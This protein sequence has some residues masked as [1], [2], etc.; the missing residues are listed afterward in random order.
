M[1]ADDLE[2]ADLLAAVEAHAERRHDVLADVLAQMDAPELR[3]AV[4][5]LCALVDLRGRI[6]TDQP[7][8]PA[9]C[10]WLRSHEGLVL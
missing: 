3:R 4:N 8:T 7:D 2:T 6:G 9:W 10:R 1:S 5:R